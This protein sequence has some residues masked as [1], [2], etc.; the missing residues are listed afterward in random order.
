MSED[1]PAV[2]EKPIINEGF[3]TIDQK[4]HQINNLSNNLARNIYEK[5][6]VLVG[7]TDEKEEDHEKI[8]PKSWLAKIIHEQDETIEVLQDA[9]ERL[10]HL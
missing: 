9:L 2:Q 3:K 6:D 4:N 1:K 8:T 5:V 10:S 7:T